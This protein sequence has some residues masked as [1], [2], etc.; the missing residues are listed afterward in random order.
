[1]SELVGSASRYF[2]CAKNLSAY[3]ISPVAKSYSFSVFSLR[4]K[5]AGLHDFAGGEIV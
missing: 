4:E 5:P 1:V 2:R 3:T